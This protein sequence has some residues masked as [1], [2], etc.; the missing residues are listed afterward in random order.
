MLSQAD[1]AHLRNQLPESF[2][3][4]VLKNNVM[5]KVDC[6][7]GLWISGCSNL[8]GKLKYL[9]QQEIMMMMMSFGRGSCVA[10]DDLLPL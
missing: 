9:H 7:T 1:S 6:T 5:E 3:A 8:L 10:V 2:C 4:S